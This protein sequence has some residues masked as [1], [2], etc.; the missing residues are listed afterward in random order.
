MILAENSLKEFE[1]IKTI[2]DDAFKIK[3]LGSLK[4]FLGL[5]VA[6]S[7]SGIT[8]SQRKYCLDLIHETGQLG[9]KPSST[10]L[11][12][13]SKI[14]QDSAEAFS[15]TRLYRKLIGKLLYLTNTRPDI[16][17]AI[18]QLSQHVNSPTI[19]HF[20]VVCRVLKYLKGTAGRGLFYPRD[21]ILQVFGF[22]DADWANCVDTKKSVSGYCFF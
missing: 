5:E 14:H 21:S 17:F 12:Y 6:Q 9:S 2:L 11:D 7:K 18:Q 16:T 15:D 4:Y 8:I 20:N 19:T 13:N 22:S 1:R 10:P 3:D